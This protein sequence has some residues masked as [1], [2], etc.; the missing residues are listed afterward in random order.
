MTPYYEVARLLSNGRQP[1][2]LVENRQDW[3]G[4]THLGRETHIYVSKLSIIG[5]D[6]GLLPGRRQ[7]IISTN[8]GILLIRTLW[9]NFSEILSEIHAFS[10]KKMHLK[11]SSAKWQ[12]FCLGLNEL[13]LRDIAI[14][15]NEIHTD[16]LLGLY[17]LRRHC[18]NGIKLRRSPDRLMCIMEFRFL[19]P[20]NG[21]VLNRGRGFVNCKLSSKAHRWECCNAINKH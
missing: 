20:S 8:A 17:S 5:W 4:L 21:F 19:G 16:L 10:F 18:L 12:P 2:K 7:A 1:S 15:C 11:V 14:Y 13:T 3:V 9:T 6:N